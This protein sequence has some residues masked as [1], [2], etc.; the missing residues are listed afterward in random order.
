MLGKAWK[1]LLLIAIVNLT[2][3]STQG[4]TRIKTRTPKKNAVNALK[5]AITEIIKKLQFGDPQYGEI[6]IQNGKDNLVINNIV[7]GNTGL[8]TDNSTLD[9][10]AADCSTKYSLSSNISLNF[11]ADAKLNEGN[12]NSLSFLILI[13]DL[14]FSRI[15]SPSDSTA[16]IY[17][18]T[19]S[20]SFDN[21][22]VIGDSSDKIKEIID[23]KNSAIT[24]A[25]KP[26]IENT[27]DLSLVGLNTQVIEIPLETSNLPDGKDTTVI[28]AKVNEKLDCSNDF[29][30]T[31]YNA[32]ILN[33]YLAKYVVP[34]TFDNKEA[35]NQ[36]YFDA[37]LVD[38]LIQSKI[39]NGV[40]NFYV[41]KANAKD[42]TDLLFTV[43]E[44]K[45]FLP[46]VFRDADPNQ[47]YS[48]KCVVNKGTY[49]IVNSKPS[50]K[51]NFN[52]EIQSERVNFFKF[53]LTYLLH[54]YA[55][56]VDF[57]KFK[58]TV[59]TLSLLDYDIDS[60]YNYPVLTD[61]LLSKAQSIASRYITQNPADFLSF[62]IATRDYSFTS[63][64]GL[65]F[66]YPDR[67]TIENIL[68]LS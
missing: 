21:D 41:T 37:S 54:L 3:V 19:F 2:S 32:W 11:R 40:F 39:L 43:S 33:S 31:N 68:R 44:L 64:G 7:L 61:F 48:F 9:D 60:S 17:S 14:A 6:V 1:I 26:K 20:L 12:I 10:F 42:Y 59:P 18:A 47:K 30:I 65:L 50:S 24:D 13:K 34:F 22:V 52:C 66:Q 28:K 16:L 4:L 57:Y 56:L 51:L 55:P 15:V 29:I 27:L 5:L 8:S 67:S 63:T 62:N 58:I 46:E 45:S 23:A 49:E 38:E 53:N 36:A 25:I 35:D